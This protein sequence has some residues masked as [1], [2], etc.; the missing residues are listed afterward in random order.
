MDGG[1]WSTRL[2]EGSNDPRPRRGDRGGSFAP[3]RPHRQRRRPKPLLA[4]HA[5]ITP[6]NR[7]QPFWPWARQRNATSTRRR[8]L[9]TQSKLRRAC[10]EESHHGIAGRGLRDRGGPRNRA[11]TWFISQWLPPAARS[12]Q[13]CQQPDHQDCHKSNP[14]QSPAEM[15]HI[16]TQAGE[17]V[18]SAFGADGMEMVVYY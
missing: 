2:S 1:R 17:S 3:A 8:V 11:C 5:T 15:S 10:T 12:S 6:R 9:Q 14:E 7:S 16:D 13:D 18:H 4:V